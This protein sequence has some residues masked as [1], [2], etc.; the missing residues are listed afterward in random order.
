MLSKH[1]KSLTPSLLKQVPY[2][3]DIIWNKDNYLLIKLN[4][5]HVNTYDTYMN[6]VCVE[7]N[8]EAKMK[9]LLYN[10]RQ[11][12]LQALNQKGYF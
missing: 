7:K 2:S 4:N 9:T 12:T 10:K 3:F 1:F 8:V 5:K 11:N 6:Q